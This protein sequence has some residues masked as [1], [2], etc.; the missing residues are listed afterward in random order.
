MAPLATLITLKLLPSR[1]TADQAKAGVVHII[2]TVSS[3]CCHDRPLGCQ[4]M[5]TQHG[6]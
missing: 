2:V 5:G 4:P 1:L 6:A 3:S